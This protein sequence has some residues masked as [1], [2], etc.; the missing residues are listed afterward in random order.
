MESQGPNITH[1]AGERPV[2]GQ[3]Q[4]QRDGLVNQP[5]DTQNQGQENNFLQQTGDS[6]KNMAQ[7][8]TT[9]AQGAV[10]GV[11]N[12]AQGTA[13]GAANI[14]QGAADAVKNTLGKNSPDNLSAY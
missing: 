12:V 13:L 5:S 1:R 9:I 4:M 2:P 10:Q 11:S 7:G 14:A 8:A 6:V 3:A